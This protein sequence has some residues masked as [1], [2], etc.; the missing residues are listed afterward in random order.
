MAL[1]LTAIGVFLFYATVPR[2][3]SPLDNATLTILVT[4]WI[5]G[6]GGFAFDF[7]GSPDYHWLVLGLVITVALMDVGSYF[8]GRRFGRRPLAPMVS[9]KKTVEGY[10]A[11]IIIAIG[12][13]A[14]FAWAEPFDLTDGLLIGAVVAIVAP[15]GD[16]AVSVLKR[17]L[18]VK[19]MGYILPGHGGVLDRVDAMIIT[20][21][22]LWIAYSW[23]GL[24]T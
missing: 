10:V 15:V 7:L 4:A 11:G 1:L 3:R 24:L 17:A 2:R 14:A 22:A 5:G 12:V 18:G 19:D 16:L 8:I 6:L 21:P 20:I 23:M 9:P 13:G